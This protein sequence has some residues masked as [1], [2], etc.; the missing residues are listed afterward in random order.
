MGTMW[1]QVS[2]PMLD[3]AFEDALRLPVSEQTWLQVVNYGSEERSYGLDM[4]MHVRASGQFELIWSSLPPE[5]TEPVFRTLTVDTYEE[6]RKIL[7]SFSDHNP[8]IEELA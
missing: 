5:A 3:R 4:S 1:R 2:R 7:L 6:A 8:L